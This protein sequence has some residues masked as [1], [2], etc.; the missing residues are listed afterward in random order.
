MTT[1]FVPSFKKGSK[2]GVKIH[3]KDDFVLREL[4]PLSFLHEKN[5]KW[6]LQV[7]LPG[8]EKKNIAVTITDGHLVVKAK[9][10]EAYTVSNHGHFVKF[11]SFKK[12]VTIPPHADAKRISAKF[13]DGILTVTVPRI[14]SGKK[15]PVE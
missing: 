2:P 6:T 12:V 10:E 8:V 11:E 3:E 7:D 1:N 15:I 5:S 13:R 9:L 4:S 14:E